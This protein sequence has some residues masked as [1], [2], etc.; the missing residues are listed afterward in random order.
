MSARNPLGPQERDAALRRLRDWRTAIAAGSAGAVV[1]FGIV[2]AVTIPGK[3][4]AST[5]PSTS[6]QDG[7]Q[8]PA[9]NG[10]DGAL[11]APQQQPGLGVGG[12]QAISGGSR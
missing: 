11:Q 1:A 4:S 7:S 5:S 6:S 2:A 8:A 9:D 3:A 10:G 12:G